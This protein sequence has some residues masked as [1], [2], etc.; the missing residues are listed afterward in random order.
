MDTRKTGIESLEPSNEA[1]VR[2]STV[3]EF[4]YIYSVHTVHV[5]KG[6]Y[7]SDSRCV[8]RNLA[9]TE[10]GHGLSHSVPAAA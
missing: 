10:L 8:S 9:W 3:V 4:S 2:A 1:A 7:L 5:S 6:L